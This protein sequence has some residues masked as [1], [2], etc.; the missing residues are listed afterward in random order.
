MTPNRIGEA[1]LADAA[2]G[3]ERLSE[4][5]GLHGKVAVITGAASG[6]G[7]GIAELFVHS[8]AKV[9]VA[10]LDEQAANRTAAM[11]NAMI[12]I[13]NA[14]GLYVDVSD[15]ASVVAL[16]ASV[17]NAFGGVDILVNNAG[18]YFSRPFV[19]LSVTDWDRIHAVNVRGVFLCMREGIKCMRKSGRG[20]SIVN[21]SSCNSSRSAAFDQIHYGS[22]KSAV[23]GITTIAA[24][25]FAPDNIRVNAILPGATN[26]EG[27]ARL[28]ASA[29]SNLGGPLF[30]PGRVPLGR[31]GEPSDIAQTALF[32]AGPASSYIT[33][34]LISVDGG[35]HIS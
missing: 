21:I 15:E 2:I 25:E 3:N 26:T 27:G 17:G 33:G 28:R 20:G 1:T 11:L 32:L 9:V 13:A 8:G 4:L 19:E 24:L 7:K 30:A 6:I 34:A 29:S 23:N 12:P 14:R 18:I 5:F 35:F 22:T 16:F 31:R 10:D